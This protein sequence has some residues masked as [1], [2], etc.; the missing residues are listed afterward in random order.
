M[1][2]NDRRM[3]IVARELSKYRSRIRSGEST[4]ADRKQ[5]QALASEY[6]TLRDSG[7][8]QYL[9][10]VPTSDGG[11]EF[12]DHTTSDATIR[13]MRSNGKF[14]FEFTGNDLCFIVSSP[15]N[16]KLTNKL[17]NMWYAKKFNAGSHNIETHDLNHDRDYSNGG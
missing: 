3:K 5:F 8:F 9:E 4:H 13:F 11:V 12:R 16:R 6:W 2:N 17:V 1:S 10:L 7:Y 15:Y 14:N